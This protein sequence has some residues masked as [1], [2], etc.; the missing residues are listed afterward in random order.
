MKEFY[1]QRPFK[2]RNADEYDLSEILD[3]FVDPLNGLTH[4]FEYEN[5]IIKGRMGSGKTIYLRANHAYYLYTV[6][7]SLRD[8]VPVTLPLLINFSEFQHLKDPDIIYQRLILRIIEQMC[9]AYEQL[10]DATELGRLH[11]GMQ[12]LPADLLRKQKLSTTTKQLLVLGADQYSQRLA[13]ELG[14]GIKANS[15]FFEASGN[16]KKTNWTEIQKKA[17]PDIQDVRNAYETL[18]ADV[19]G[20][21]LLL[22]DEVGSLNKSFF[23]PKDGVSPFETIMN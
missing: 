13:T 21:L 3:L 7:P 8:R 9:S 4:P 18:L 2:T 12:S 10:Q 17:D 1:R 19:N 14:L 5:S 15:Q 6:L 23:I 16:Y 22:F 11:L 20:R